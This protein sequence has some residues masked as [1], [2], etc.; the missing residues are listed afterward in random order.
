MSI[1]KKTVISAAV[2]AALGVGATQASTLPETPFTTV[3]TTSN[4]FTMIGGTGL[5]TGGNNDTVFTWDGTFRTAVVTDHSYNATLSSA[6]TFFGKVWT[7]HHVNIYNE[8]TYVFNT[9]CPAGDP[10]CTTASTSKKYELIVPHGYIGAHMLFDWSTSANIDVVNLWKMNAAWND[11]STGTDGGTISQFC[12]AP[13]TTAGCN[14]LPNPNGNTSATVWNGVSI[15]TLSSTIR[16]SNGSIATAE[17]SES[18]LYHGTKMVDGP[19]VGQS[20]NFNINGVPVPAAVWL[21]GSGL[22]GLVGVARRR[23]KA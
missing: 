3:V 2:L 7:A 20:A 13:L 10:S 19:F 9:G 5:L 11:P 1:M 21:L 22:L 14:T 23:K 6:S 18:N 15:D 4:N 17:P 8:G 16:L 12:A